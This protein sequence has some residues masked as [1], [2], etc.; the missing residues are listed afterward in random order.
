MVIE[1]SMTANLIP[2]MLH[3]SNMLGSSWPVIL[4]TLQKGWALPPS[5]AFRR[6]LREGRVQVRYLPPDTDMFSN[7]AV[8]GFLASPW[9]WEQL[10]GFDRVLMFQ[11]DSVLCSHAQ[12]SVDDWLK[13]DFVGAPIGG[14]IPDWAGRGFNGGLS[15]RNPKLFLDIAN[16]GGFDP[17]IDHPQK[18]LRYEDQWFYQKLTERNS[19][20][21]PTMDKAKEFSV[22]TVYYEK[23]LGYHQPQR[24]QSAHMEQ[25]EDYCPEVTMMLKRRIHDSKE[26]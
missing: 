9:L 5:S 11:T 20:R 13:W 23:P 1:T 3:F 19:T 10:S 26:D 12:G 16:Q 25:I 4:F 24:W 8:S 22:E 18:H 6:A 14:K 2:L 15:L 21:L 17:N 7:Q